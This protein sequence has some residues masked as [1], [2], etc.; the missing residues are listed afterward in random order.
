MSSGPPKPVPRKKGHWL[1]GTVLDFVRNQAEFVL[2]GH[3]EYGDVFV[4]RMMHMDSYFVRDPEIVN[5]VNVTQWQDFYKPAMVKKMWAPFLGKGLV[6]NDGED[7]K[8]QH[9]LIMPAFSKKRIDAYASAM[10]DY[11]D[12][13]I[14]RWRAGERR[15]FRNEMTGL[16]LAV[17]GKTIFDADIE[18]D[19][20]EVI[21]EALVDMSEEMIRQAS[22]QAP[23]PSW[24][25]S[26]RNRR[27]MEA[28]RA[29]ESVVYR[30]IADRRA[31][32]EDRGDL[33]SSMVFASDEAGGMSDKQLRD[34]SMTLV[35][36]GHETT[37]HALT[38]AWYLLAT[39][40]GPAAEL[41]AEIDRVLG[42]RRIEV[43]DMA[44]LPYLES[45]IKETMRLIPSVWIFG[46]EAQ[47]DVR[48]GDYVFK[49]GC[50]VAISPLAMGRNEKYFENPMEFIP[51]RWTREFE[52]ELPKGA[53]VPFAA[54]PRVCLGK[55]FAMMEMRMVLG[56]LLQKVVPNVPEGF[57]PDFVPELSLNPGPKGMPMDVRFRDDEPERR[58][59]RPTGT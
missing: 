38:W 52:R 15:D 58:S 6:P 59:W 1:L 42:G 47:R 3:R 45:V 37:A 36:A 41:R 55:Q 24:W 18:D 33:L 7:W 39:N 13:M 32:G 16:T 12:R 51:G 22:L 34:E 48:I 57:E 20:A 40:P 28:I 44:S 8:R 9:K 14:E 27:K 29:I 43:S 11:T 5:A 56:T 50:A 26:K 49:K 25:P 53:Y 4:T 21:R 19:E 35:F 23:M 2:D 30:I 46:R 17:V 54:G 10:V 31:S